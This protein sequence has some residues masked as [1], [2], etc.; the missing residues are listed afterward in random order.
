MP[1]NHD[2][3]TRYNRLCKKKHI[4]SEKFVFAIPNNNLNHKIG[5]F[6]LQTHAWDGTKIISL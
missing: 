3:T 5:D 2:K 6:G 1:S 4:M